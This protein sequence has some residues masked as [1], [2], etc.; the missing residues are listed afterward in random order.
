MCECASDAQAVGMLPYCL[1]VAVA[2]CVRCLILT[3]VQLRRER[4]SPR[5]SVLGLDLCFGGEVECIELWPRPFFGAW[6]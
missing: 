2:M 5:P 4:V 1:A 6:C 3:G